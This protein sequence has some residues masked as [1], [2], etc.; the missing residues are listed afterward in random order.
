MSSTVPARDKGVARFRTRLFTA[1][2]LVVATLTGLGFYL[3]AQ[4]HGR[5]RA[6]F[7]ANLSGRTFFAAQTR[8]TSPCCA[9]GSLQRARGQVA[10]PRGHRGQR[11]R[12]IVS[13]RK[14]RV[15]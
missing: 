10:N 12:P 6:K 3:A 8:G 7:A 2:M 14:G 5:C 15:A 11:N 4:G 13:E 1:M 9:G